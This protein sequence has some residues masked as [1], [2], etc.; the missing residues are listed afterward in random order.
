MKQLKL[1]ITLL[2]NCILCTYKFSKNFNDINAGMQFEKV[3]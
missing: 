1:K 3:I 2:C